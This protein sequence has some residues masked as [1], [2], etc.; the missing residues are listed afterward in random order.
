V[1][2]SLKHR[3]AAARKNLTELY[4]TLQPLA[5]ELYAHHRHSVLIGAAAVVVALGIGITLLSRTEKQAP[6]PP[7]E[8]EENLAGYFALQVGAW[9]KAHSAD[10]EKEK[11]QAAGLRVR[12]LQPRSSAGWYR[13]HVGKYSN[14]NAAQ[15]AADSLKKRGVIDDYFIAEYQSK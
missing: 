10:Q 6:P 7:V 4:T 12:I 2:K 5:K 1:F 15:A 8:Q 9:K 3:F 13:I 14:R 11:L